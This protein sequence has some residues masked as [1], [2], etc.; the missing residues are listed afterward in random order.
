MTEPKRYDFMKMS[1]ACLTI[2]SVLKNSKG[3]RA[4]EKAIL[5]SAMFEI[6]DLLQ[7]CQNKRDA[8]ARGINGYKGAAR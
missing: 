8:A 3:L 1:R 6:E 2:I 5:I 7:D 4:G